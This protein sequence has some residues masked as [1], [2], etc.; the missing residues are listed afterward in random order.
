MLDSQ[1]LSFS[2][3]WVRTRN[4]RSLFAF[5]LFV[6]TAQASD[7]PAALFQRGRAL[8]AAG[9]AARATPLFERAAKLQPKRADFHYWLAKS[10]AAEARKSSDPLRLVMIGWSS[11]T[12]LEEAVKLDPELVDA[13]LDL[14]RYYMIAPRIVG[15]NV[16]KAGAQV[17]QLSR[18]DAGLGAFAQGYIDYREKKYDPAR[19]ELQEA[20]RLASS[21]ERKELALLWLGYLSQETQK[22]DEAFDAF[23]QIP[24]L[25]EIG[26]T[27]VFCGCRLE[28]GEE[29]LRQYLASKP[30]PD[31]P[32]LADA[33]KLL[34]Q[35]QE[36][37]AH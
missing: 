5:L 4:L 33:K 9:E 34:S 27:A 14:I 30:G 24:S 29:A 1:C 21:K 19:R 13:R 26:R 31:D 36:K 28:R 22:Y 20:V 11:G 25:Y 2:D 23:E 10:Y 12:E 16:D 8:L 3:V 15:G 37:K 6:A 32:S 7:D 18:R 35:L 17:P